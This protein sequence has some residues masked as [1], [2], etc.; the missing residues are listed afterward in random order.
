VHGLLKAFVVDSQQ[1]SDIERL[2]TRLGNSNSVNEFYKVVNGES[3]DYASAV[4]GF[5]DE[6]IPAADKVRLIL[7]DSYHKIFQAAGNNLRMSGDPISSIIDPGRIFDLSRRMAAVVKFYRKLDKSSESPR[8]TRIVIDAIRNPLELVYLRDRFAPFYVVAIT[9]DDEQRRS[10]LRALSYTNEQIDGID[11]QEYSESSRLLD[12]YENLVSQ[13]VQNCIQK[14]DIFINNSGHSGGGITHQSKHLALKLVRYAALAVHPGLVTPTRDERCMQIAFVTKLNSGCISRQVGAVVADKNHSIKSVGWNDVAKGQVP[15]LLRDVGSLKRGDDDGAF[16]DYELKNDNF[17]EKVLKDYSGVDNLRS[18]GLPCPYCFKDAYND[19]AGKRE[20]NQVHTRS[21]H[22][23][24][25]AFLQL[26]KFGN[27]GIEGGYL[28]TTASPCELCSKKAYQLGIKEV[29]YVDPYPGISVSHVLSV[30]LE[31]D[32]P[33]LRLF[34][35]AVGN[36]YHRLYESLLPIKD[37]FL[38]RREARASST[39]IDEGCGSNV[40]IAVQN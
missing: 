40:D 18:V 23:E 25:N 3:G 24:E 7:K 29:I 26:A 11:E 22:A 15:C 20:K 37:E 2:W 6:I 10:R 8:P 19:R 28:Y 32:R 12:S 14:S 31:S 5:D 9:A 13:N 35:G 36:A 21:L 34:S 4:V 33:K 1:V 17:K 30:G 16:S 39:K 38:A 27:S